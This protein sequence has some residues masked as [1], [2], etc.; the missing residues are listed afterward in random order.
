MEKFINNIIEILSKRT[1]NCTVSMSSTLKNNGV[2]L[3]GIIF[4]NPETKISPCIYVNDLYEKYMNGELSVYDAS[5]MIYERYE[6]S[7]KAKSEYDDIDI[8]YEKCKDKIIYEL[9]S[10]NDNQELLKN[11]PHIPFLD[12]AI[13]MLIVVK[14]DSS[15]LHT[16]KIDNYIMDKWN[17]TTKD[18]FKCAEKNTCKLLPPRVKSLGTLMEE[19]MNLQK[20]TMYRITPTSQEM[21]V[22]TNKYGIYGA[23]VI[24]YEELID[25]IANDMGED[26]LLLPSSVHEMLIIADNS[27]GNYEA[28]CRIIRDINDEYVSKEEILSD[29]PYKYDRNR[30]KIISIDI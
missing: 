4:H 9:I 30:K 7:A 24:I 29:H 5:N 13:I 12:F 25:K 6:E 20:D 21:L 27:G 3:S 15:G 17:M 26:L 19:L 8:E 23:S 28:I 14:I 10:Y 11:I 1:A 18:L 16:I 22:V 2:E